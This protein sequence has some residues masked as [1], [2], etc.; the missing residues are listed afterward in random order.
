MHYSINN[1]FFI[2]PMEQLLKIA[3]SKFNN[4]FRFEIQ[5]LMPISIFKK[6]QTL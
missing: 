3:K 4:H 5:V 6:Q 2:D 1:R